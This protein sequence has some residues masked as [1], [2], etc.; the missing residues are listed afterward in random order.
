MKTCT[1]ETRLL[2]GKMWCDHMKEAALAGGGG[3][4]SNSACSYYRRGLAQS[5]KNTQTVF[6]QWGRGPKKNRSTSVGTLSGRRPP[7]PCCL[8]NA[9]QFHR[10]WCFLS[11]TAKS[12]A[13][14]HWVKEAPQKGGRRS[15]SRRLPR[16]FNIAVVG[17]GTLDR[18]GGA[19]LGT[20]ASSPDTFYGMVGFSLHGCCYFWAGVAPCLGTRQYDTLPAVPQAPGHS[21][22]IKYRTGSEP[23]PVRLSDWIDG[24]SQ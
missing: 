16:P 12:K 17:E 5:L 11:R 13:A 7:F 24:A 10:L 15:Q 19:A 6:S 14:S 2:G 8:C 18:W 23:C 3:S 21:R 22:W 9:S 20:H 1:R 4:L